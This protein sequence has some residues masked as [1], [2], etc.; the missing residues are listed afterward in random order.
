V[1]DAGFATDT[2]PELLDTATR[3]IVEEA[4][5]VARD[6]LGMEIAWLAE[7]TSD[8]RKV[9]RVVNG[10]DGWGIAEGDQML[11]ADSYCQR[12]LD[13]RV[14][15]PVA[16]ALEHPELVDLEVTHRLGLRAYI[17]APL[18]VG[19]GDVYGVLCIASRRP[20]DQA[21]DGAILQV[22]ARLLGRELE[23]RR[24]E[25]ER[26]AE[27]TLATATR[28][29]LAA[30]EAR[31]GYTG[32]HSFEVEELSIRVAVRLG[33]DPAACDEVRDVARLHDIGKVGVPDRVLH[34][35]GALDPD[36]WAEIRKHPDVGATV[37]ASVEALA[38]LA[39][40]VR[41]EHER[42]DGEG[43]PLGLAGPDIPVSSR[44]VFVCDAYHAMASD[45]P[46]R[47]AL[48][49]EAVHAELRRGAGTQFWPEAVDALLAELA[50]AG[51]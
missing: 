27:R 50:P 40:A 42:W 12:V 13:G 16:D 10:G 48:T 39:P 47:P 46:Y 49:P 32:E 33:L 19:P 28:A 15:G 14:V 34:K 11:G 23:R 24:I 26:H 7:L 2:R 5:A 36:E 22:L 25:L 43:Y 29:L 20:E 30:L 17:G 38:H 44:I 8:G 6:R 41:A 1:Q 45:R 9:F 21:P 51:R 3:A 4:L 37:L 31:D 35:Q 18:L